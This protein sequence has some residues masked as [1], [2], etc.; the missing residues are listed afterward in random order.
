MQLDLVPTKAEGKK[1]AKRVEQSRE[2]EPEEDTDDVIKR[3]GFM[4][5]AAG[6]DH[7]LDWAEEHAD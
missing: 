7:N 2:E 1:P 6:I 3:R 5:N 4:N